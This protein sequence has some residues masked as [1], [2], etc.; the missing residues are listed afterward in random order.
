LLQL[1]LSELRLRHRAGSHRLRCTESLLLLLL[2]LEK[3][4]LLRLLRLLDKLLLLLRKEMGRQRI[5]LTVL[6]VIS[7]ES[8][9]GNLLSG[10]L[11]HWNLSG[12]LGSKLLLGLGSKL[13]WLAL[14][15]LLGVLLELLRVLLELLRVLSKLLVLLE[16][17]LELAWLLLGELGLSLG[18]GSL[19]ELE[20]GVWLLG[21]R[22]KLSWLVLLELLGSL[23]EL[24]G[25]LLELL[26][27]L[28]E[29]LGSL[30]ELLGSLL[31]LL[32]VLSKL[33]VL[34]ELLLALEVSEVLVEVASVELLRGGLVGV[35]VSGVEDW[36][37]GSLSAVSK[38]LSLGRGVILTSDLLLLLHH[39]LLEGD[40]GLVPLFLKLESRVGLLWGELSLSERI[41]LDELQV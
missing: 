12:L 11:R 25:S 6:V 31:E 10:Q 40:D 21:L 20:G 5:N 39:R 9:Q 33:L 3:L 28:L 23:L 30:L 18:L 4:R 35:E 38:V 32:G 41:D 14:L 19:L 17:S 22:G 8:L 2:L 37:S 7:G 26:G 15:E 27:I 16:L 29:L 13:S 36:T 34:L 1:L 24:L